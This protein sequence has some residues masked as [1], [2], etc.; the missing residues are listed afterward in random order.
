VIG[1][2]VARTPPAM[3]G[4]NGIELCYDTFGDPAN[5]PLILIMGLAAQMVVWDEDFLR[6]LAAKGVWVIRFD[7]RDIGLSTK[8]PQARTPSVAEMLLTQL[9]KI[10]F[11]IPYTLRDMAADTVGLMDALGLSSANIAGISM[12]G[13]IAQEIAINFPQRV[14]T[15]TSIMASTGD[16]KL[17]RATP[18]AT[19]VLL[20][21][22]PLE[23]EAY[24]RQYVDS[25]H[26]LAG[27]AFLFDPERMRRQGERGYDRGINPP[28][29]ARQLMAIVASGNRTAALRKLSVPTRVVHGSIDP[30]I[31]PAHG[32]ATA[33]AIPGAVLSVYDGMGH[34]L[35]RE[36]WDRL[37]DE[38]ARHAAVKP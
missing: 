19:A 13:A 37:T 24:L 8:F 31:P 22:T 30:L 15:L 38:L 16:P 23:R 29:V 32:R 18:K 3:I 7:N 1:D 9:T 6:M 5:P 26:V 25:W 21:K 10:K 14:R 27:D 34:T 35:P 11:R 4:A 12:G 20:R 28:G 2:S 17:P 36:V 33:A